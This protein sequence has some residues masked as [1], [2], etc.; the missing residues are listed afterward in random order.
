[1]EEESTQAIFKLVDD[2]KEVAPAGLF[3]INPKD[4]GERLI[5][6]NENLTCQHAGLYIFESSYHQSN[7]KVLVNRFCINITRAA[8]KKESRK[9]NVGSAG[10]G[11]DSPSVNDA[12]PIEC[13]S[14]STSL[15][16]G[17]TN[18][19]NEVTNT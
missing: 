16:S 11:S 3:T 18:R 13:L 6:L 14:T 19:P 10:G 8:L 5:S 17:T 12:V 9:L 4:K 2:N 15:S 1:M 7:R